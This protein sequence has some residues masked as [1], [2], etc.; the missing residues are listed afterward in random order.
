MVCIFLS[1]KIAKPVHLIRRRRHRVTSSSDGPS[2]GLARS[3]AEPAPQTI[4]DHLNGL[5]VRVAG[6]FEADAAGWFRAEFDFGGA[7][8]PQLDRFLATEK[9]I[10]AEL[11]S[12]AAFLETCADNA[13]HLSLMERM[14]Q[15]A[16]LFTLERPSGGDEGLVT[17]HVYSPPLT[18][19]GTY[20]IL[21]STRGVDV[22]TE[23]TEGAGI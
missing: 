18:R 17:L 5:G 12:W 6:R 9:G 1:K 13:N 20:S 23:W 2:I 3:A 11:S 10:R 4:L 7:A 8:P 15:T 21:D 22:W 16:Q 14:I 19:M